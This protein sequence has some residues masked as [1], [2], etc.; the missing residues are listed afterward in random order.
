MCSGWKLISVFHTDTRLPLNAAVDLLWSIASA[1][2]V[3]PDI[4]PALVPYTLVIA[5]FG[6][7]VVWNGGIVL[8][9]PS[10][11]REL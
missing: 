4:L 9:E 5:T 2:K 3:L 10:S 11:P 1:P 8:G 7:F 6:A